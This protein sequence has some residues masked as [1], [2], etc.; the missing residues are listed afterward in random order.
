[1]TTK[2]EHR[3]DRDH[4]RLSEDD[5]RI[6]RRRSWACKWEQANGNSVRVAIHSPQV[7]VKNRL[8]RQLAVLRDVDQRPQ[9]RHEKVGPVGH[10]FFVDEWPRRVKF[11]LQIL[12][13]CPDLPH[14][15][16]MLTSQCG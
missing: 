2:R 7:L 8:H 6:S 13:R 1:W 10:H 16:V 4:P 14:V 12:D 3:V 11:L 5:L 9:L 15:E